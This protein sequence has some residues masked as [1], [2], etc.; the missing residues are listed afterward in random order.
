[1][2]AKYERKHDPKNAHQNLTRTIS[3]RSKAPDKKPNGQKSPDNKPHSIIE[4][5]IAKYAV[6]ANLF[7]LR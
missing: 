4:D 6:E 2:N 1:M 3:N 5:S 7:L